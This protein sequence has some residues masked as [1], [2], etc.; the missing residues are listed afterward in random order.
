MPPR[1]K[2]SPATIRQPQAS[3]D[4]SETVVDGSQP[5]V[6]SPAENILNEIEDRRE[7]LLEAVKAHVNL[8]FFY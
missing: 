7:A 2:A 4:R 5:L 8:T 6:E 1:K 3:G